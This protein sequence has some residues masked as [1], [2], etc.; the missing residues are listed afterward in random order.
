MWKA[1]GFI[2]VFA[3]VCALIG[4]VI[5]TPLGVVIVVLLLL[6]S[7]A[8][9]VIRFV[10]KRKKKAAAK[11]QQAK[12]AASVV[13]EAISESH[14]EYEESMSTPE[15]APETIDGLKRTYY[16]RDYEPFVFWQYSGRYGKSC[17]SIGMKHGDPVQFRLEPYKGENDDETDFDNVSLYWNDINFGLMRR[18]RLRQMVRDWTKAGN[19]IY[20]AVNTVGGEQHH[21]YL[22]IAFYGYVKPISDK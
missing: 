17:E 2:V 16:Y 13:L 3:F 18:N 6:G 5:Q 4:E 14:A 21:A 1:I 10:K 22:E 7:V 19:P 12:H 11:D 15:L 9:F 20:C 8:F